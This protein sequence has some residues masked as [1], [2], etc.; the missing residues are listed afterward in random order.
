MS[1][2]PGKDFN[3]AVRLGQVAGISAKSVFGHNEIVGTTKVTVSP[4]FTTGSISQSDLAATPATVDVA[5][6]S[7]NDT[8]TT[9]TGARTVELKGLDASGNLQTETI[10]IT[11]QT[12]VTSANTYSAVHS[13]TTLTA[14]SSAG[15]EGVLWC[16]NG[17]FTAGVPATPYLSAD[18]GTNMSHTGYYVVPTGKTLIGTHMI[19]N[20]SSTTKDVEFYLETSTDGVLWITGEI[21]GIT[22]GATAAFPLLSWPD[23]VAGTHIRLQCRSSAVTTDVTMELDGYLVD[24]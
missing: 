2:F 10:S 14:G 5:S 23:A 3:L 7:A 6:T 9:G 4:T 12:E 24:D 17:T 16:G 19:L 11:G 21:F 8:H 20:V 15:N 1:Y 18:I 13:L 22:D